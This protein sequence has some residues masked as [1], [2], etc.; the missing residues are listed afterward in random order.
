MWRKLAMM[1][2]DSMAYLHIDL[3]ALWNYDAMTL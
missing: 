1:S 3:V 2:Y